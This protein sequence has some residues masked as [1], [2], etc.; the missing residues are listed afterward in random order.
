[1][2]AMLGLIG[3]DAMQRTV[4][5][6]KLRRLG[7]SVHSEL[8]NR[9]RDK[10]FARANDEAGIVIDLDREDDQETLTWLQRDLSHVRIFEMGPA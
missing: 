7:V 5:A 6:C 10:M 2:G 1:M 9:K 3:G 4:I 8:G